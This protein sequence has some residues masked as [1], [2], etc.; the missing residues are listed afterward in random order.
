MKQKIISLIEANK[1][2]K[3]EMVDVDLIQVGDTIV[4]N[5]KQY[6]VG[7]KDIKKDGFTGTTI[8]GEQYMNKKVERVL[9]PRWKKD[10]FLGWRPQ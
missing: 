7:K 6:T 5:S 3:T 2:T 4:Q 10:K 9:F 8:R 1:E